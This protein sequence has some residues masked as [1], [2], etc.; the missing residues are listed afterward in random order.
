MNNKIL[1]VVLA[2]ILLAC[3]FFIGDYMERSII[4]PEEQSTVVKETSTL[5]ETTVVETVTVTENMTSTESAAEAEA[6]AEAQ[7]KE[8]IISQFTVDYEGEAADHYWGNAFIHLCMPHWEPE[9][10]FKKWEA[11]FPVKELLLE[12]EDAVYGTVMLRFKGSFLDDIM[13]SDTASDEYSKLSIY[14]RKGE[15]TFLTKEEI[16][17]KEIYLMAMCEDIPFGLI[18]DGGTGPFWLIAA[19]DGKA[20]VLGQWIVQIYVTLPNGAGF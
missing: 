8:N 1:T 20:E 13:L 5:T 7:K 12:Y 15:E 9:I 11:Q 10:L 6:A 17:E 2:A 19:K 18:D 14:N 16:V 3:A 4:E